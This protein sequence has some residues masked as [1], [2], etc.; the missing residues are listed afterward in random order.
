MVY[1]HTNTTELNNKVNTTA[2][3]TEWWVVHNNHKLPKNFWTA[4]PKAAQGKNLMVSYFSFFTTQVHL[5][6]SGVTAKANRVFGLIIKS[7]EFLDLDMPVIIRLLKSLVHPIVE[8]SN[9][10]WGTILFLVKE[11]PCMTDRMLNI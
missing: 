8:Y 4:Q 7:F 5:H 2:W 3:V 6:T 11:F 1:I 10:V 9:T